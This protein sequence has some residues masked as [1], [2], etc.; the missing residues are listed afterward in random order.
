[1]NEDICL[2]PQGNRIK[3]K[4]FNL[5]KMNYSEI[6]KFDCGSIHYPRFPRQQKVTVGKPTID[7]LLEVI[8][9]KL[10]ALNRE[11]IE[12][13]IEIKSTPEDE[14]DGF[15]P[16]VKTFSDLVIKTIKE[17]IPA[18]KFTIQSFDLRVLQYLNKNHPD[19]RLVALTEDNISPE[20]DLKKLGFK[21][22]VYSPYYKK[23]KAKHVEAFHKAGVK[24]IVW[25]VNEVSEMEEMKQMKVDGIITD[26]PDLIS[27]VGQK[28]CKPGANLFEGKCVKL[29]S[30]S[31]PY[32]KNPGWTCKP[33]YTQKRADCTKIKVPKHAELL[34]D[35][36]TW[37]CNQGYKRY[38]SSCKKY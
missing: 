32:E 15:Q 37:E 8:E 7:T 23:L 34:P 1:M 5:F 14:K 16:D 27:L 11:G 21:P 29:P 18:T 13:N 20:E 30:H 6:Q 28:Q 38:R 9:A 24:V 17:K 12:Y 4:D 10:K 33:G 2:D 3:G 19:I 31:L 25:T 26:Y 35:G 36:K 22:Y